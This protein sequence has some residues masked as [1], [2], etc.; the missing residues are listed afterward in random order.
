MAD[1]AFQVQYRQEFI[2]GFEQ[3]NSLLRDSVTTEAVVKGNQATFL[4]A[5]SGNAE[6]VTRGLNGRIPGR[7]DNLNQPVATLEEW[8]DKVE[9]TGFNIFASQGDQKRIMQMTSAATLQR[10]IDQQILDALSVAT[11]T[12]GSAA[13]V[14]MTLVHR[15]MVVLGQNEVPFDGGV[16]AVITPAFLA[17]LQTLKEFASA[18]YV[19][20]KPIDSGDALWKDMPSYYMWNGIKWIVHTRLAGLGTSDETCYMFHRNA[21][22]HAS[23]SNLIQTAA[24]YNDED[25]FSYARTTA[26]MGGKLLQNNGVVKMPHDASGFQ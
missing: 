14:T 24:G 12:T 18:D 20:K 5:D 15:A 2:A 1:T 21:I 4:V 26:Y 23:P 22:A 8:H 3:K 16:C 13:A 7:A 9:K 19:T 6:A 25:D 10:K 17:G 11:N